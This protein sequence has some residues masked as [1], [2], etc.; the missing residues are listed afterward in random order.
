MFSIR[1]ACENPR[2]RLRPCRTLSPSSSIVC[3]PTALRRV[4]SALAIVDF[5]TPPSSR[6]C[7]AGAFGAKRIAID[8]NQTTGFDRVGV[9]IYRDRPLEDDFTAS[10]VV[11]V[12]ARGF[13]RFEGTHVQMLNQ[14]YG[15][16]HCGTADL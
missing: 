6:C 16:G 9:R 3:T 4:S 1:S 15:S 8:K 7:H 5:P 11:A 13:V 12:Q 14:P 2:S 10:H